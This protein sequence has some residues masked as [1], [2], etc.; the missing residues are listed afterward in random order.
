MSKKRL[1]WFCGG[2]E[3][4]AAQPD[5]LV[6][7]RDEIGLTTIMPE[8]PICH[9]SG[10]A[11][12]N[13]LAK[14]GPFEDWR[15]RTDAYPRA[16]EGIYPPV[17]GIV[18]GFDDTPL[19]RLIESAHAA[20]IEVWGHIGLWSY[21]GDVY[22]EYAMR[23]IE[24]QP[25][26]M[27]YQQWGIGLC[28][29]RKKI[30]DWTRDGLVDAAQRY[31]L[32]GFCVDH[33]RYPA[34]ANLHA[35][36]ACGC[37]DCQREGAALGYDFTR[38]REGML[39]FRQSLSRLDRQQI[40]RM[41]A[42]QPNLWD[43]L[44]LC[45][46]GAELLEWLRMRAG[47]LAARMSEFRTAVRQ[48]TSTEMP[49]GSDVFPPSV[50]LLGGHDYATWKQGADYLTGGSS[51]GGVVGWA[52][53]VTN[54]AGE[55]APAL[56]RTID[57][58]EE[59]EALELVYRLFGYEDFDL[60]R[61][62]A[63]LQQDP[64]PLAAIFAREVAKLKAVA[65]PAFGLYPPLSVS[66]APATVE[67]LCAAVVDNECDG[68]MLSFGATEESVEQVLQLDI[69]KWLENCGAITSRGDLRE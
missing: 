23:D 19:R 58:L 8:S 65:D 28:P 49:F 35:L 20:G 64:L 12:S 39:Q 54:L 56:C 16:A 67:A 6:K 27:R 44:A 47:L 60:P 14:R 4:A 48:A 3:Q 33:A 42:N 34:P 1:I 40:K 38:L 45:E 52:T 29:S 31:G 22:P 62:L 18:S 69:G 53:M 68:A 17:A 66:A 32:D 26:D 25:L 46:G 36:F 30:N 21:G 61:T 59:D 50:A 37:A 41:S 43:F 5:L 10:F 55:W 24:G 63:G 13:E 51:F 57:G 9:T 2:T 15:E 7:L 11:T